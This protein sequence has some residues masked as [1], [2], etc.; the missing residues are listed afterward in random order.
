MNS[1]D[2]KL[3]LRRDR[4]RKLTP[5]DIA[6]ILAKAGRRRSIEAEI[7]HLHALEHL[8]QEE[9]HKLASVEIAADYDVDR[10][11]IQRIIERELS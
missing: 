10:R 9:R 1:L 7:R 5:E 11:T 8:L 4:H 2:R 3:A 6:D